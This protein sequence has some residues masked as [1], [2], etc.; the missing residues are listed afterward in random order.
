MAGIAGRKQL[1]DQRQ[2][3]SAAA[4]RFPA[5]RGVRP[6]IRRA[7]LAEVAGIGRVL[8]DRPASVR[9]TPLGWRRRRN[10]CRRR[11]IADPR[12][13]RASA[14]CRAEAP[15]G[16]G[17]PRRCETIPR[18]PAGQVRPAHPRCVD[19]VLG[20]GGEHLREARAVVDAILVDRGGMMSSD[21]RFGHRVTIRPRF[22]AQTQSAGPR[23]L[24]GSPAVN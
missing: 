2:R 18:A 17:R 14:R 5:A 15:V 21:D 8:I 12:A 20:D 13:S 3:S 19:K 22:V 7:A 6:T 11:P 10:P 24:S 23:P 1:A 4:P 16:S 9:H